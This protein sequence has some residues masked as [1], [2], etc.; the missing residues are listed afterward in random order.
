M[1]Q[2]AST[3]HDYGQC[4]SLLTFISMFRMLENG[5]IMATES[6]EKNSKY[7]FVDN[8]RTF[9]NIYASAKQTTSVVYELLRYVY[10]LNCE[11]LN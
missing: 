10:C 2:Y 6:K 7:V 5:Y 8:G 3:T 9:G 1:E 4:S 11:M